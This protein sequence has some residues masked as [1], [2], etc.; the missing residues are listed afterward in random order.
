[1]IGAGTFWSLCTTYVMFVYERQDDSI[2][3]RQLAMGLARIGSN[4]H[5]MAHGCC[6][7]RWYVASRNIICTNVFPKQ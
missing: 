3:S 7:V 6:W 5:V 4:Y 1:M 2:A